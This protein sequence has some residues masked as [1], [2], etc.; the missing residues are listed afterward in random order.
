MS[1]WQDIASAPLN[2]PVLVRVGEGMTFIARLLPDAS[3]TTADETCDQWQ[4]EYED[5]HPPCWSDGCCWESN[6]DGNAS[7]Q[8]RGWQP[9]PT[10]TEQG[11]TA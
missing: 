4:A 3:M 7:L 8:P 2:T 6:E 5:E 1:E 9:L 10:P 11:P